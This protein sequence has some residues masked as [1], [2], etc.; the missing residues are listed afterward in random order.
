M[1]TGAVV[2]VLLLA[3]IGI[4]G[5]VLLSK[6]GQAPAVSF[7]KVKRETIADAVPTNGKVEPI[8]WAEAR[9]ERAGPI[10]AI[11][12]ERGQH[13]EKGAA[14]VDLDSS[15]AKANLAAGQSRVTQA[16]TELDVLDHGGRVADL[17]AISSEMDRAKLELA[18]AQKDYDTLSRLQSKQAATGFEV[19]Q[20]KDRV[21]RA[22]AQIC[23]AAGPNLGRGPLARRGSGG[24][25]GAG[26]DPEERRSIAGYGHDLPIR[27]E[28]GSLSQC[29]RFSRGG[30]RSFASARQS[31]RR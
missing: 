6:R 24:R 7:V 23:G 29:R 22:Q 3:A 27:S 25:A 10:Q 2:T 20:A 30:G 21:D 13:V 17:A 9:A 28:T 26:A 5:W 15:E 12:V 18:S 11:L 14:L 8:E 1:K 16:R 31:I 19:S 4:G